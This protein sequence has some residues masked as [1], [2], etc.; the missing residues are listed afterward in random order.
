[1]EEVIQWLKVVD[2]NDEDAM[3]GQS[4]LS[5]CKLYLTNEHWLALHKRKSAMVINRDYAHLSA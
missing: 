4:I 3:L 1:M 5:G 2:D